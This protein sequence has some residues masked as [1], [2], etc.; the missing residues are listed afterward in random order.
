MKFF[1]S[2]VSIF[3]CFQIGSLFAQERIPNELGALPVFAYHKL[4]NEDT[5]YTRSRKGF[6][7]DMVRLIRGGF[8]PISLHEFTTGR[9]QT[10]R[11]KIPFLLTFDDSSISQFEYRP[12]G[13]IEP[14]CVVGILE[15]LRKEYREFD[16]KAVFFVLPAAAYPNNYFGQ[17]EFQLQKTQF[18][19]SHGYEIQN[20]TY[21]HANL[22]KYSEKIEEQ[23]VR[24]EM[25]VQ[26]L[27]PHHRMYALAVPFGIYPPEKD[28]NRLLKGSFQGWSYENKLVFDFSNRLSLSPYSIE[29]NPLQVHRIH[30]N[31]VQMEKFFKNITRP[32]VAFVSDGYPD[33]ITISKSQLSLLHPSW[34][35]KALVLD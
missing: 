25:F 17:K 21:W 9:I 10:P 2:F 32:G 14:E 19:L 4:G 1:W 18:L 28:R 24:T 20:H 35:L 22:K 8:H 12:D 13:S 3:L 5:E 7:E 11:G 23:I 29:F 15:K 26:K 31:K 16:P 27:V 30:G 33:T 34:R 6:Q